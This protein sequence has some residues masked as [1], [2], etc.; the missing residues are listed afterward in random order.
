M[1][2]P[3]A[4]ASA[5]RIPAA[6]ASRSRRRKRQRNSPKRE[7]ASSAR[8][9]VRGNLPRT[10]HFMSRLAR[11]SIFAGKRFRIVEVLLNEFLSELVAERQ[12]S[13]TPLGIRLPARARL[14]GQRIGPHV[15]IRRMRREGFEQAHMAQD[16]RLNCVL[17]VLLVL[18][19]DRDLRLV[20]GAKVWLQ[21][22]SPRPGCIFPGVD[23]RGL[24]L[25]RKLHVDGERLV[26]FRVGP[27][28][29]ADHVIGALQIEAM[30]VIKRERLPFLL[31]AFG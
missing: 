16:A 15:T 11:G 4:L 5:T 6:L 9:K 25:L 8:A 10:F 7:A 24:P 30:L 28:H 20:G 12:G 27:D 19:L 1:R 22:L 29:K 26:F 13:L 2:I 18:D 21:H 14:K 3:A 31:V 23:A 17:F